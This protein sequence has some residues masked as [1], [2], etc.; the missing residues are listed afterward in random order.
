M[1]QP[2]KQ[3]RGQNVRSVYMINRGSFLV[4]I[5]PEKGQFRIEPWS[6]LTEFSRLFTIEINS[7]IANN[8]KP[9]N[10]NDENAM[11]DYL[12][13]YLRMCFRLYED[14]SRPLLTILRTLNERIKIAMLRINK[15]TVSEKYANS[16]KYHMDDTDF[17]S[18]EKITTSIGFRLF[19]T[20]QLSL[21]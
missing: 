4:L 3:H 5:I 18:T 17:F 15:R 14:S 8:L 21:S 13:E 11:C 12:S 16:S 10:R 2:S 6:H 19:A 7:A 1:W 9:C 20:A